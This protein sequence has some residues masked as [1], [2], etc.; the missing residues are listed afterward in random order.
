MP[1]RTR[2]YHDS[3]LEGLR[4][5]KEAA[6]YVNAAMEDSDE[7]FLVAL[8]KVAEAHQLAKVAELAGISRES[9]YRTLSETGNP[10]YSSLKGILRAVGLKLSVEPS[11]L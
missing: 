9:M 6:A 11:A 5:P 1:K 3:L 8:R 7:M 4:D 2:K 10:C